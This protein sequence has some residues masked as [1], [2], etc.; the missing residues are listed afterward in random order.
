MTLISDPSTSHDIDTSLPEV[1]PDG[2]R[3]PRLDSSV[4][5]FCLGV[6]LC[7]GGW[8]IPIGFRFVMLPLALWVPGH[9]IVSA[10]FGRH[11]D[12]G[13]FRRIGLSMA[14]T[15]AAYPLTALSGLVLGFYWLKSTVIVGTFIV[16]SLCAAIIWRREQL[17]AAGRTE[18]PD[19]LEDPA[20]VGASRIR[21]SELILPF[22]SI[23]LALVI[24][25]ASLFVFPRKAPD[26]YSSIALEG[27]WALTA[28]AVPANPANEVTVTY[29]ID[30]RTP[31]VQ[32]YVV[33]SA[34]VDGPDWGTASVA[35]EPGEAYVGTVTGPIAAGSCRSRLEIDMDVLGDDEDHFPLAVFFRDSTID[36]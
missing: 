19:R 26:A 28:H 17:D 23:A 2:S 10:A 18:A 22:S 12:F 16:V 32:E 30:N 11:L 34:V 13:G 21:W 20:E 1:G 24:G 4:T 35:I 6:A 15:L 3:I 33:R 25:W 8:F 36:C 14:L 29:R 9:A 27:T 7:L 5:V 31:Q